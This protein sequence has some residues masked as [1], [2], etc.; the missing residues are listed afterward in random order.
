VL[1][2]EEVC[3]SSS[4]RNFLGR[5]GNRDASIYLASPATVAASALRGSITDP[6]TVLT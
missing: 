2:G 5:M 1:A 6:R 3:V 4:S